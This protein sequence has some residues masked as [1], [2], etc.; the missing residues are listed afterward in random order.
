MKNKN[1]KKKLVLNKETVAH[2]GRED[3]DEVM[4]GCT[5]TIILSY[6]TICDDCNNETGHGCVKK[7]PTTKCTR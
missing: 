1:Q 4:G 5:I 6:L 3:M 7:V 2:L